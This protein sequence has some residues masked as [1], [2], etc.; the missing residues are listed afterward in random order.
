[1]THMAPEVILSGRM[2]KAADVYAFGITLWEIIT[3]SHPFVGEHRA[4]LGHAITVKA[5]R[6]E[7]G[8]A[9][10]FAYKQ[11]ASECWAADPLLRPTF[12][13]VRMCACASVC[14]RARARA[15]GWVWVGR[16][17]SGGCQ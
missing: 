14:A 11:L 2:S 16:W 4:H 12:T 17:L 9:V 3:G 15:C 7:F 13:Q 10:P 8:I 5:L 1:M 6:P